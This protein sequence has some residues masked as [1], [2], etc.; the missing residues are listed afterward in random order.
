MVLVN[1]SGNVI[2]WKDR[3]Y[4][5]IQKAKASRGRAKVKDTYFASEYFKQKELKLSDDESIL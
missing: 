5:A 2:E 4:A 1:Y 3:E